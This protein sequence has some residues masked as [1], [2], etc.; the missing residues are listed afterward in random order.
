MDG[1]LVT[2][3]KLKNSMYGCEG[4]QRCWV[5]P[6]TACHRIQ[7][8]GLKIGTCMRGSIYAI[9]NS[10]GIALIMPLL[11]CLI[12]AADCSFYDELHSKMQCK[13][14]EY[15]KRF[16]R[17]Y[18]GRFATVAPAFSMDVRESQLVYTE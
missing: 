16:G 12:D 4:K 13:D 11:D 3:Q 7:D 2:G 8:H 17:F 6:G 9:L 15:P 18:C 5:D 14:D 1:M 10:I